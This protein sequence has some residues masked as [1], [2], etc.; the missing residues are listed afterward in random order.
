MSPILCMANS[1]IL[2]KRIGPG[3]P[4]EAAPCRARPVPLYLDGTGIMTRCG[5]ALGVKG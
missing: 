5:A 4:A 2:A 3:S 1:Q